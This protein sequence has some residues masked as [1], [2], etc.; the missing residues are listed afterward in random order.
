[1]LRLPSTET[2]MIGY[3]TLGTNDLSRAGKSIPFNGEIAAARNGT[4]AAPRDE[5]DV[6]H[7][8]F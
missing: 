8:A 3:V 2:P 5:L 1:M 7:I 4:I 6:F